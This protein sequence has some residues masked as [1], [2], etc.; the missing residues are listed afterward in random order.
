M[1]QDRGTTEE[2]SSPWP[3]PCAPPGRLEARVGYHRLF[4]AMASV[5][6]CACFFLPAPDNAGDVRLPGLDTPLP[7][8]C[9]LKRECGID[10]P[11]CGLTRCFLSMGHGHVTSA[12]AYHPAGVLLFIMLAAQIPYRLCQIWRL[13]RGRPEFRHWT[14]WA[15]LW[16]IV[17]AI[18]GQ[19]ILRTT[20][21]LAV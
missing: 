18:L 20:G 1:I 9:M 11:G 12:W 7:T 15:L 17:A 14:Q 6:L 4:L 19:W 5:V 2:S 16:L 13:R 3:P 21:V 10:C 8:L